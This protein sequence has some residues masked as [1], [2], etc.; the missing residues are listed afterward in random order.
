MLHYPTN[1]VYKASNPHFSLERIW[2][3]IYIYSKRDLVLILILI[4]IRRIRITAKNI[5]PF[6]SHTLLY[7]LFFL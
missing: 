4:L 3:G 2:V 5:R 7:L 6:L 1:H